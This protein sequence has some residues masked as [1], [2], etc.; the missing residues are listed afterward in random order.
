MEDRLSKISEKAIQFRDARDWKQFHDPKNLAEAIC[1]ESG[2]L[3]EKFLWV[4]TEK[5]INIDSKK[6]EEVKE[7]IADIMIFLIYLCN[8]L[9]VD[10]SQAVENKI[11]INE[12]KY[13]IEK[14]KGSSKKYKELI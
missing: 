3:L 4:T 1:I 11:K 6:L 2:E 8:G 14:A 13:P 5:S 12:E 9:N 10:L 7:E